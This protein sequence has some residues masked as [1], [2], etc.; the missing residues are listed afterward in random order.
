MVEN[1]LFPGLSLVFLGFSFG[2]FGWH[3]AQQNVG[4]QEALTQWAIA[5]DWILSPAAAIALLY[6]LEG[7]SIVLLILML[8]AP[9]RLSRVILGQWFPSDFRSVV[10]ALF[11]TVV[12]VLVMIFFEHFS[13]LLI[14]IA[15][16]IL[17]HL[18]LQEW[19]FREWQS[20]LLLNLLALGAWALG[21][22][23]FQQWGAIA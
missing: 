3:L 2:T 20:F 17:A 7:L 1:R 14:L 10:L 16:G 21:L 13:R 9:L 8:T 22:Y 6:G 19:G 5:Q 4:W 11:W 12:G 18:D 15:S 23:G